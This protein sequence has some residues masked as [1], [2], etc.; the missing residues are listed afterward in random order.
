[1]LLWTRRFIDIVSGRSA[2]LRTPFNTFCMNGLKVSI[3]NDV[4][5]LLRFQSEIC[6]LSPVVIYIPHNRHYF[7]T[8]DTNR[9]QT[10]R[11]TVLYGQQCKSLASGDNVTDLPLRPRYGQ[12]EFYCILLALFIW[13]LLFIETLITR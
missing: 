4:Y 8:M 9:P 12:L 6:T 7:T 5:L 1:M 2:T 11:F 10:A 13:F 3:L